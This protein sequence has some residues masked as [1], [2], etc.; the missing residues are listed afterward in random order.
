VPQRPLSTRSIAFRERLAAA[1]ENLVILQSGRKRPYRRSAD[2]TNELV[3]VHDDI[4][5]IGIQLAE[6]EAQNA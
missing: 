4:R 5:P 1:L 3:A 2:I 6:Y